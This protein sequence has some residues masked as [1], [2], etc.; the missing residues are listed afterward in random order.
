MKL[1][2]RFVKQYKHINDLFTGVH[3]IQTLIRQIEKHAK[4]KYVLENF[5]LTNGIALTFKGEA[6]ELFDEYFFN[7]YKYDPRIRVREFKVSVKNQWGYDFEGYGFN[8]LP[9]I[10]QAKYHANPN[11]WI[12]GEELGIW[13]AAK[14]QQ[15]GVDRINNPENFIVITTGAGIARR[16]LEEGFDKKI[17]CFARPQLEKIIGKVNPLFWNDLQKY[18]LLS[19]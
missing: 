14:S 2:H 10:I 19:Q 13:F 4:S 16:T 6:F 1:E 5:E 8:D 17:T 18:I 11:H 9:C 3:N 12:T 15:F 7:A